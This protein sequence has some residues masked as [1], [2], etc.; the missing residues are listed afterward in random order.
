MLLADIIQSS[1]ALQLSALIQNVQTAP[2][3]CS[4]KRGLY[5]TVYLDRAGV[6]DISGEPRQCSHEWITVEA[7]WS[8]VAASK[9]NVMQLQ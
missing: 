6:T 8:W 1:E 7:V 2:P 4:K 5:E 9:K 3:V